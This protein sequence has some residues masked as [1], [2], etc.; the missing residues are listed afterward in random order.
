LFYFPCSFDV[1]FISFLFFGYV[2]EV[3][4]LIFNF[5]PSAPCLVDD[6]FSVILVD[7][8]C[9]VVND[10]Q[11]AERICSYG[12]LA[13]INVE[14]IFAEGNA[15]DVCD[16]YQERIPGL[17]YPGWETLVCIHRPHVSM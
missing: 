13:D 7:C 4:F 6:V 10:L 5:M 12:N 15:V 1:L 9:V 11:I 14:Y 3:S 8:C 16:V 17:R 2:S